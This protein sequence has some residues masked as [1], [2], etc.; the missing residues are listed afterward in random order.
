MSDSVRPRRRQPASLP[1]VPGVLQARTL[2]WVATAFSNA[3]K[4]RA[5]GKS[6]SRVRLFPTPWTAAYRAPPPTGVSGRGDWS[7]LPLPSPEIRGTIRSLP[8]DAVG[9]KATAYVLGKTATATT[10]T[11][12]TT[13]TLPRAPW[14]QRVCPRDD[15][16]VPAFHGSFAST[17]PLRSA[18]CSIDTEPRLSRA[19][20]A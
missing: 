19:G 2:E 17:R 6:L 8:I 9:I 11:T 4:G 20:V 5:K 18:G 16:P 15:S 12:T 14:N 13:Q 3:W 1:P 7:G 10:T